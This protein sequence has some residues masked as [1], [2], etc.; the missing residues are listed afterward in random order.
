MNKFNSKVNKQIKNIKKTIVKNNQNKIL[1]V[2]LIILVLVFIV[3]LSIVF[4]LRERFKNF[5]GNGIIENTG[6]ININVITNSGIGFGAL[7][8]NTILVYLLQSTVLII[9]FFTW[10]FNK[11]IDFLIS[12]SLVMAGSFGNIIDRATATTP[13]PAHAVL[14]YFQFWFG[15][16][17]FNFADSAIVVGFII[18][19]FSIIV[20]FVID[21]VHESRE[22][23]SSKKLTESFD[24]DDSSKIKELS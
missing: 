12:F 6:F 21:W 14:D 4:G 16:A 15:G 13:I 9:I 20:H 2:K 24:I 11:K 19:F 8:D 1:L 10:L 18:L 7:N 22:Q 23:K 3:V 17:I 5:I